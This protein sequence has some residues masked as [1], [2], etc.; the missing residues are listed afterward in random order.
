MKKTPFDAW[1]VL[2]LYINDVLCH[3]SSPYLSGMRDRIIGLMRSRNIKGLCELGNVDWASVTC[4]NEARVLLQLAAFLKKNETLEDNVFTRQAAIESFNRADKRCR[5]VN[6]R[7]DHYY[8][9]RDRIDP[10]LSLLIDRAA[11]FIQRCLGDVQEYKRSIPELLRVTSGASASSPK[12]KSIPFLKLTRR[13]DCSTRTRKYIESVAE[14]FGYSKSIFRNRDTNRVEFVP[15]S[16]KTKRT[17]ACEPAGNLP[18]QLTLDSYIKRKLRRF[19]INLH[20]QALNQRLAIEGSINNSYCTIDLEAASDSV[21]L[22]TIHWLFPQEWAEV[23]IDFRSPYG[24]IGREGEPFPYA[25]YASMGNGSTFVVETLIFAA[26]CFAA[27]ST[28]HAVYGDD[29]IILPNYVESLYKQLAFFGFRINQDKTFL[30]G[31]FRESCGVNA[32]NGIDITPFHYRRDPTNRAELCH[33]VNGIVPLSHPGGGLVELAMQMVKEFNLPLVP[34]TE[35]TRNGVHI[36]VRTCY[37][38]RILRYDR[39]LH[40]PKYRGL[41]PVSR[42]NIEDPMDSRSLF[43]WYLLKLGLTHTELEDAWRK[44]ERYALC[45]FKY[46]RRWILWT[47]PAVAGC[48]HLYWWGELVAAM[49]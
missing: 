2:K 3:H 27:G 43:L 36:D 8:V 19:G 47:D 20:S 1:A 10:G 11:E 7:L 29:I 49:K 21:A 33:I 4:P 17:I 41:R 38:L 31:P 44:S 15:K 37:D 45:D 6:R 23:L 30:T 14:V 12:S 34:R 18:F 25:K 35:D 32:F 40:A 28:D 5:I 13:I 46:V 26:F 48:L 24:Q 9:H 42:T 39:N 22:N 16:Y